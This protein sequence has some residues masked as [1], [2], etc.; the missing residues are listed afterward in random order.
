MKNDK[1]K[2]AFAIPTM[3][4][5]G[6]E[7]VMSEVITYFSAMPEI[8]CHLII[9]GK[10]DNDFYAVPSNVLIYKPEFKFNEGQR[11]WDTIKTLLFIRRTVKKIKPQA[12][13]SFG[14]YWNNFV[15][16]S[17]F[18]LEI[19]IFVSDR[20]SP[21]KS[22]GI[23][24]DFLRRLLYPTAAGVIAQT[25]MAKEIF[26]IKFKNNDV[27]VIGNPIRAI[28]PHNEIKREN[29]I[30]TVGRLITTKNFN[31]L[32]DIFSKLSSSDW[33]L[34][35]VGGDSNK[36]KNSVDLQAQIDRLGLSS[37]V[38]LAGT[39]KNVEDYLLRSKIF[40]FTSSSEGFPNVIGEAMS[41]GL[42]VVSYDCVTGPSDMIEDGKSG[43]LIPLFDDQLFEEKL[44]YLMDNE[45]ERENMG[46]YAQESIKRFSVESIGEQF[47]N[48]IIS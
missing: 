20:S 36:Q 43:F 17:L 3:S 6:M 7:R 47:Y 38:I 5:G 29:I 24:H 28:C 10:S 14:E 4:S 32:I 2:I 27:R 39:Q 33:K 35:I 21:E 26:K 31:H 25:A 12:L 15:L 9:Y 40:A 11:S 18:G 30:V 16:L 13:L 46:A 37:N 22:L 34:V 1:K 44:R 41:A 19:P 45:V 8:E 42:P 48:F 23:F